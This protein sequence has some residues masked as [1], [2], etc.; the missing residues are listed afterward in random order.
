MFIDEAYLFNPAPRGQRANDSNKV[1]D[2]LL[3]VSES[4]ANDT[5]FILAGYKD[6]IMQLLQYNKGFASRF[7]KEF[8]FEFDDYNETQLCRILLNM[9]KSK[10]YRFESK[11]ECGVP[12]ARV[13]A[14]RIAK[15]VGK[16]GFG[17]GRLC[18]KILDDCKLNQTMRLGKLELYDIAISDRDHCTLT[19]ADTVGDRPSLD[20]SPY[21]RQ[22]LSMVGLQTVK[23][24]MR[25]LINL[26]LQN[27][28]SEMRGTKTQV[29]G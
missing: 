17:N 28:D 3:K 1:L 23:D 2:Y 10:G 19:R 15:G 29:R 13:L 8:T 21:F 25:K 5:T 26:Q 18:E 11:K 20:E 14:R 4:K 6:E 27:F 7:P 12:I 9:V 24:Q 22:L 16:K